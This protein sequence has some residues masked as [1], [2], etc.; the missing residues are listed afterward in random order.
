MGLLG[1]P[2]AALGGLDVNHGAAAMSRLATV[3]KA[4]GELKAGDV[5]EMRKRL[6]GEQWEVG[7]K[8]GKPVNVVAKALVPFPVVKPALDPARDLHTIEIMPMRWFLSES[9]PPPPTLSSCCDTAACPPFA[10][11]IIPGDRRRA[12]L[13][14]RSDQE[15]AKGHGRDALCRSFPGR[16]STAGGD[17]AVVREGER[18]RPL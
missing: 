12:S 1:P 16:M 4:T 3:I 17:R 10:R 13:V 8:G 6:D 11:V 2:L 14:Q 5:V 15:D 18:R 9:L 7:K